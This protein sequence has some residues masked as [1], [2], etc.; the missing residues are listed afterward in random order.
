[1]TGYPPSSPCIALFKDG[2]PAFV[3][4]RTDLQQMN[5][6]QVAEAL[7]HAFDA[8]CTRS[9]PSIDPETYAQIRP[10]EGCGSQIPLMSR[11]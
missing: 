5:E 7:R 8:H 10:Y 2:T 11:R 6:Q 3:L 4:Q 9:G 1:M